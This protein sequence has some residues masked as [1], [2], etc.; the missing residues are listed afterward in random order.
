MGQSTRPEH[1]GHAFPAN[2]RPF[3][4]QA[5]GVDI[6]YVEEGHVDDEDA[7]SILSQLLPEN[8]NQ[9]KANPKVRFFCFHHC[10]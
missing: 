5:W 7:S 1:T 10:A 3:D 9:K 8:R 4:E 2:Y 6:A